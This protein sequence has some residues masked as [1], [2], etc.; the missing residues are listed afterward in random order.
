ML[1]V[2]PSNRI[3]F[4]EIL[5]HLSAFLESITGT[6]HPDMPCALSNLR[7]HPVPQVSSGLW[8][9]FRILF[10]TSAWLFRRP[11]PPR[12]SAVSCTEVKHPSHNTRWFHRSAGDKHTHTHTEL[13]S[14]SSKSLI[15]FG[16]GVTQPGGMVEVT[17]F[18]LSPSYSVSWPFNF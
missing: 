1:Q 2:K 11:T 13:I 10:A 3:T 15:T 4:G 12:P 18:A 7:Q 8:S 6:E 17:G 16:S 14:Q 9:V 5:G